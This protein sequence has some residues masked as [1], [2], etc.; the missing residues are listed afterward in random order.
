M[1]NINRNPKVNTFTT[2]CLYEHTLGSVIANSSSY[3]CK[4]DP[5]GRGSQSR[6]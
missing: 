3:W 5:E 4:I 2:V 6:N 1:I